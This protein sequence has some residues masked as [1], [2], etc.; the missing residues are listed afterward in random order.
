L[1]ARLMFIF[2]KSI[3]NHEVVYKPRSL[4]SEP[5]CFYFEFKN[6]WAMVR[7]KLLMIHVTVSN[8]DWRRF[9]KQGRVADKVVQSQTFVW[10]L[11]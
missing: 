1:I 2:S 6:H 3:R 10:L 8:Q 9:V 5:S 11:C 7:A 4:A